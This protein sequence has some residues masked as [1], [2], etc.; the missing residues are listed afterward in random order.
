MTSTG[1][2]KAWLTRRIQDPNRFGMPSKT[3]L[4]V[5]GG[6]NQKQ[7]L[8]IIKDLTKDIPVAK[9]PGKTITKTVK[10]KNQKV[11]KKKLIDFELI[12]IPGNPRSSESIRISFF[13]S[14]FSTLDKAKSRGAEAV[15][16]YFNGPALRKRNILL[17]K[18]EE[19]KENNT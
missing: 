18:L 9:T 11:I 2:F 6:F 5:I 17:S 12:E 3:D 10:V 1:A 4:M 14:T 8:K 7:S 16:N 15:R 13:N 19:V